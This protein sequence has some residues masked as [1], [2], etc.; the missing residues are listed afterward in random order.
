MRAKKRANKNIVYKMRG[1]ATA[2]QA[3]KSVIGTL[4]GRTKAVHGR[5]LM[6]YIYLV[7]KSAERAYN[8]VAG[9]TVAS[10][11]FNNGKGRTKNRGEFVSARSR[12]EGT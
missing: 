2:R 12:Q 7:D 8:I 10:A 11:T 5:N 3:E 6:Q 1:S 9:A 4:S